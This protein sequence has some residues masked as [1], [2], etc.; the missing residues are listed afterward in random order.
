[1][2]SDR[3]SLRVNQQHP[4][5][6]TCPCSHA[7][8]LGNCFS[9]RNGVNYP[10]RWPTELLPSEYHSL[11]Y[12]GRGKLWRNRCSR[13]SFNLLD[14][15]QRRGNFSQ[16]SESL[17]SDAAC[18]QNQA[19]STPK[20]E[21]QARER[22]FAAL[23]SPPYRPHPSPISPPRGAFKTHIILFR[24]YGAM[25]RRTQHDWSSHENPSHRYSSAFLR[26]KSISSLSKLL[27][28]QPPATAPAIAPGGRSKQA[29][30]LASATLDLS[31]HGDPTERSL[32]HSASQRI[33]P[34]IRPQERRSSSSSARPDSPPS[35]K[36]SGGPR[37]PFSVHGILSTGVHLL[38]WKEDGLVSSGRPAD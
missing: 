33:P 18:A 3:P 9:S 23:T 7:K 38:P 2:P 31:P 10:A 15:L 30:S 26:R 35:P 8:R 12:Y 17:R 16:K 37:L 36:A 22:R 11:R 13:W 1:M 20:R 4:P 27:T 14:D 28:L 5:L 19:A 25:P 6:R 34:A 24:N 21:V 29:V 32:S